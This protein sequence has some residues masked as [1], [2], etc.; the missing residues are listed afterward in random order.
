MKNKYNLWKAFQIIMVLAVIA[1][2][3]NAGG[4]EPSTWTRDERASTTDEAILLYKKGVQADKSGDY[5]NAI[6][7]FQ[8]A[9][10]LDEKNPNI[11]N[12]LAHSQRKTGKIDEALE[13]Y[14]RALNLRPKFPE[15]R[16]YLG[17][18]YI[19]AALREIEVLKGYGKDGAGNREELVRAFK[20]AAATIR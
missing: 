11:L 15:A 9:Y 20:Q 13:N 1:V 16:E 6:Q 4:R 3:L 14:R 18:A 19:Q 10:K 5:V 17:E 2:F 12:M 7:L 8:K